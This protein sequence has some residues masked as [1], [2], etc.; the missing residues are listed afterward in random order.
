MSWSGVLLFLI[1]QGL[2]GHAY[3]SAGTDWLT[4]RLNADG[5]IARDTDVATAV[6]STS[7]AVRALKASGS[8]IPPAAGTYL[9]V[10][11]SENAEYLARRIIANVEADDNVTVL[12]SQLLA[13]QNSDGGFGD[14]PGYG[15]TVLDT[16]FALQALA[17]AG[18]R[19]HP[20][21]GAGVSWLVNRQ[22][23][24]GG[25]RDGNNTPSTYLTALALSALTPYA[26]VYAISPTLNACR[27]WLYQQ[28]L[29]GGGWASA[30]ETALALVAVIPVTVDTSRYANAVDGLRAAQ[31]GD[32]S[33]GG[34]VY[35]TALALQALRLAENPPPDPSLSEIRGRMIDADTGLAL[36]GVNIAFSGASSQTLTTGGDGVF[37]FRNL[38]PASYSL[39]ITLVNYNGL[40]VSTTTRNGQV[41]D[42]G[43]IALSRSPNATTGTVRG[44]ITDA[45]TGAPLPGVSVSVTGIASPALTDTAGSYQLTNV[46][47]GSVTIQATKTGYSN[48]T[49]SGTVVA[50]GIVVFS[51][52]LTPVQAPTTGIKG[53]VTDGATGQPLAD[54]TVRVAGAVSVSTATDGQGRYA[55]LGL[56]PGPVTI[57]LTYA[58]Y[59]PVTVSATLFENNILQF[60]P[61]LYPEN[62]SPTDANSASVTGIVVDSADSQPLAG[63]NISA[64][65]GGAP[66]TVTTASD[67]RF[68][69]TG[70]DQSSIDL[71]FS[72]TNYQGSS[73][74]ISVAPAMLL[75][76]G[77]IRLRREDTRQLLPDLVVDRID[78]GGLITDLQTIDVTGTV[79]ISIANRG[80]V[81]VLGPVELKVFYDANADGLSNGSGDILLGNAVVTDVDRGSSKVVTATVAGKLPFRDAPISVWVDSSERVVETDET[82]NVRKSDSVC[83]AQ[84]VSNAFSPALKWGWVGSVV[85]S[86]HN[87]VIS[88]PVVAPTRDTNGDGEINQFDTPTV[89]FHSYSGTNY[90]SNGVL[91]ALDGLTGQELWAISDATYRTNPLGNLA[92][93]DID[94]DGMI[95]IIAPRSAG[96]VIAFEHDGTFKWS[97]V[98]PSYLNWGAVAIADIDADGS[99]DIVVGNT[100]LNADGSLKWQGSGYIGSP[101]V[102]LIPGAQGPVSVVADLDMDGKQEII[103]G[104]SAYSSTGAVLWKNEVVGDGYVGIA[105]F[106]TT[107]D[108]EIVVVRRGNVWLMNSR[109]GIIWG[110]ILLPGGGAGGSPVIADVNGDGAPNIGIAGSTRYSVFSSDGTILWTAPIQ[111]ISSNMTGSSVFDFDGDGRVEIVYGDE[112]RLYVFDGRNGNVRFSIANTSGTWLELPV[113]ADVDN[114]A[115]ADIVVVSNQLKN[116]SGISGIRVY[117][118]TSNSW[119]GTRGIW[120]QHSYHI[121]NINDDGSIPRFEQPSWLSH[122]TYR[123]NTFPDRS[124]LAQ[125]DLTASK[126][127]LIDNGAGQPMSLSVRIGNGGMAPSPAGVLLSFYEGDPT[128]GG[129]LLGSTDI[130]PVVAGDY[131]DMRLDGVDS[132]SGLTDLYAVIDADNRVPECNEL[133][134]TISRA[135]GASLLGSIGVTADAANYGAGATAQFSATITNTGALAG[136]FSAELRIT[137]L[138]GNTV[139][140]FPAMNTGTLASGASAQLIQIWNT[141]A[142]PAGVYQLNATLKAPG[143]A[144][145]DIGSVFF[146]IVASIEPDAVSA[147]LR[148]TT[149][150]P[151]YHTTA[152]AQLQNLAQ[153]LTANT[154]IAN[155][156]LRVTVRDAGHQAVFARD[157][158]LGQLVPGAQRTIQTPY[159]FQNA[160]PGSYTVHG[161]LLDAQTDTVL[162]ADEAIYDVGQDLALSVTGSV[163][164]RYAELEIGETQTCTDTITNTGDRAITALP[165]RQA[166]IA[167]GRQL[168]ISAL[169]SSHD[170][171]VDESV[172]LSRDHATTGLIA[173]DYGCVLQAEIDGEW[174]TLGFA[175]FTLLAPPNTVPI[176]NAGSDQHVFI[177][178]IATL[179]GSASSDLD[180]DAL[181]YQWSIISAPIGSASVLSDAAAVMPTLTIDA[182]GSYELQ[183]IVNDGTVDSAPDTVILTVDNVRPVAHAGPDQAVRI[184]DTAALDGSASSDVDGDALS[185]H[186]TMIAQPADSHATLS[187]PTSVMPTLMIDAYGSYEIQLVVNDGRDDSDPDTVLL[188]VV[189]TPPIANAGPDQDVHIGDTVTLDGTASR[190]AD[191][192]ALTYHWSLLSQP[193]SSASALSD[194]SAVQ[195]TLVIDAHGSYII[196]LLVDDGIAHSAPD[197][198]VLNVLNI[199]PV[200]DTGADRTVQVNEPV[201]LDGTASRDADGDV[202]IYQWSILNQPAG[203]QAVLADATSV[204]PTFTPDILGLYVIQLIVHDG[205]L[206]SHPDTVRVDAA[207]APPV[208]DNA[209]AAPNTLWPPNHQLIT[210]AIHG[211]IDPDGDAIH[212]TIDRITQDEAVNAP[213]AGNTA[214]D[215]TITATGA[216]LR[217]ERTGG[218]NGRVYELHFTAADGK[219]GTCFGEVTVGVP[220][221]KQD[222]PVDDGQ[223]Y[224]ATRTD[225]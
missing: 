155:A 32:G 106:D 182:H 66:K 72:L 83:V 85:Q 211:A 63:V 67:G 74:T 139:T 79:T 159:A 143:G 117:Q 8:V 23:A 90:G 118:D 190:D 31:S 3:A 48:S 105:N 181:T 15:S 128:A 188:N 21:S 84:P 81:S 57:T 19:N 123:L 93:G 150:Q 221:D 108:P 205:R 73:L 142:T 65:F 6:Q 214:P 61:T 22:S 109:G 115:H 122:N 166:F 17:A 152:T 103:A 53:T 218:G 56:A 213:G 69:I 121:S 163:T 9:N 111:D 201:T 60:S 25:W 120:N 223:L 86:Q 210:V 37:I 171:A 144:V 130:E 179:D 127:T 175:T 206:D 11:P 198:V 147:A 107:R 43:A 134:N 173:G 104:A 126:L 52:S 149:D 26:T 137:D 94:G 165:I 138:G 194:P 44:T 220:H 170:L 114:D 204:T 55:L 131:R 212:V 153:N 38:M 158:E 140:S 78:T 51:T 186:W 77:Q 133:N 193:P 180:G 4:P 14:L 97:S 39:A 112:T 47:A 45:D 58:G 129:V 5:S 209:T 96:G 88:A 217:A 92:V 160:A 216:Q 168:Q 91:R 50:G 54:V 184:G 113:I 176:A 167:I 124:P 10:G 222:T 154:L 197:T 20:Q 189:N 145:I 33:W 116:A 200:A 75:D 1:L 80:L 178:E 208:C 132:V 100:V 95:E 215:A 148:T 203:S 157:T 64:E 98:M 119:I 59:D 225:G 42:L 199:R 7:E 102:G 185:Y 99:A 82:N 30:W 16:A 156:R 195:P 174:Q 76:I 71:V 87:Q 62:T 219:G 141:G 162:A 224:H 29:A 125:P 46:P 40:S 110:P 196:Q 49:A 191:G 192:D 187:D 136:N 27:D 161:E 177:G 35:V 70:I 135:P 18:Q 24:G 146:Q 101:G 151:V 36:S 89:I 68:T 183:L 28:Q 164:A 41:T 172:V 12:V 2:I 202:L 34:D 169:D 207:N 13:H